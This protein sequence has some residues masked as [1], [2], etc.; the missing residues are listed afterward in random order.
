MSQ[1]Y[2]IT[3]TGD[4]SLLR[5][6]CNIFTNHNLPMQLTDWPLVKVA[7]LLIGL[8]DI[9]R[10]KN[11]FW[12]SKEEINRHLDCQLCVAMA[13]KAEIMAAGK[14]KTWSSSCFLP[15]SAARRIPFAAFFSSLAEHWTKA[16]KRLWSLYQSPFTDEYP[17]LAIFHH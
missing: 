7:P 12:P 17:A 6:R 2:I 9:S 8:T 11:Q 10:D 1:Y 4:W 14:K 3:A 15:R 16:I 5:H 13:W